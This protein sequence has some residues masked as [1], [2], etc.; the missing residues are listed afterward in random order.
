[1]ELMLVVNQIAFV[2]DLQASKEVKPQ[3]EGK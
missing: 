3:N 1:M 2:K